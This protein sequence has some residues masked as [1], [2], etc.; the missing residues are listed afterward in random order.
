MENLTSG[1]ILPEEIIII[2]LLLASVVAILAER[3]RVPY[4]VGLVLIGLMLTLMPTLHV[5]IDPEV[6]LY[7]LIPP[8]IFEAAF[9]IRMEDLKRNWTL[10]A[11]LAIPG[12][13][14]NMLLVAGIVSWGAG[15]AFDAALVFGALIAATDPV[16]VVA[17][18]RKLGAPKRLQVILEGESLFNDGTAIVLFGLMLTAVRT[19]SFSI[20]DGLAGFLRVAGGGV[21]LGA[22][23][24]LVV[25]QLIRNVDNPMVENTLITVLAF[26]AY[27]M[28]ELLHVSGVL[29]VVAAGLVNG[30]VG[31]RGMSATTRVVVANFWE[32]AAFIAN[33]LVFLF[34]GLTIDISLLIENWQSILLA[35]VGTLVARAV[36]V[37]FFSLF[38]DIP[39]NWRHILY[40]GGLRGAISLALVLSLPAIP[41][42]PL[43]RLQAM[44]F[45]V[46]LFTLLVQGFSMERLTKWLKLVRQSEWY[47][48]YKRRHARYVAAQNSHEYLQRLAQR[49]GLSPYTWS[50]ISPMLK[51]QRD[52][53]REAIAEVFK[54]DPTIEADELDYARREALRVQRNVLLDLFHDGVISEETY[55]ELVGEIDH[56]LT[57]EDSAPH[58]LYGAQTS[59]KIDRLMLAIVQPKDVEAITAALLKLG[60]SLG[61]LPSKGNFLQNNN[62]TL[63]IGFPHPMEDQIL[64]VLRRHARRRAMLVP[65]TTTPRAFPWRSQ[66][67]RVGGAVIFLLEVEEYHEL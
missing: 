61:R 42:L 59:E 31:P 52:A 66:R 29:A 67:I 65:N 11:L 60:V 37:Y 57:T 33:S 58:L 19:D 34:V 14:V 46:V 51:R 56:A 13:I 36:G 25:S 4:T 3:W 35:I 15:I 41:G 43:E 40:W 5:K 44:A 21:M 16:A 54:A 39:W 50:H 10:I 20:I 55:T 9:H 17:L 6:I 18:F 7:L 30:N 2:L 26:G 12:V 47:D 48:E 23:L 24:G 63:L 62:V 53:L 32:Y 28:G 22:V 49:G 1:I 45:G 64:N 38:S 27:L 8:L